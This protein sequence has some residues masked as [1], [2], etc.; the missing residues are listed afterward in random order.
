MAQRN[1]VS[2]QGSTTCPAFS[3][4]SI[5][6]NLTGNLYVKRDMIY[7]VVTNI[8][9]G[10]SLSS[11]RVRHQIIRRGFEQL[12]RYRICTATVSLVQVVPCDRSMAPEN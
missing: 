2:L 1:C 9:R 6:T 7:R 12:H 8:G 11:V 4:A 3:S 10:Q 5:D